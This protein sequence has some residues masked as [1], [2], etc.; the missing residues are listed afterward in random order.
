MLCQCEMHWNCSEFSGNG[1]DKTFSSIL[2]RVFT[3]SNLRNFFSFLTVIQ[4][5]NPKQAKITYRVSQ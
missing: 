3:I 5:Y 4:I 2:R 1:S